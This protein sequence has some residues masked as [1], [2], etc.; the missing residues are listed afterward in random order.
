MQISALQTF[1]KISQVQSFAVAAQELNMTTSA[2]S[3]QMKNLEL[4]LD[5]V[6]FDRSFRPPLLTPVGRQILGTVEAI[7]IEQSNL[8]RICLPKDTL[9]G[10]FELGL[11]MTASVRLLPGFLQSAA[12]HAPLARFKV[13]TGLS[14]ELMEQVADG[15][16]DAAI[17]TTTRKVRNLRFDSILTDRLVFAVPAKA[18]HKAKQIKNLSIPFLQF[19]PYSG[20]GEVIAESVRGWVSQNQEYIVLDSIETIV[21][22]VNRGIGYTLLP[23]PDLRRYT[24]R[25]IITVTPEREATRD[26]SL[27]TRSDSIS[28]MYCSAL[29]DL[30]LGEKSVDEH[31]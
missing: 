27:V 11:I 22:C 14:R 28:A 23:E 30:L 16:L 21:E 25:S 10:E 26:I 5:A 4:H 29:V 17:V 24:N 15:R 19:T 12:L 1:Y 8:R 31:D 13:R 18:W 20:V 9:A 6:L 2:V 7:V 3:M